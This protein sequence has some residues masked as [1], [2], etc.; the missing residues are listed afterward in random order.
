MRRYNTFSKIV[1]SYF[2]SD[3]IINFYSNLK[4]RSE[5]KILFERYLKN[6][7]NV[8]DLF[9]A[10][11][12][13][14]IF[15]AKKGFYVIG[16]DNNKKMIKK[17]RELAKNEKINNIKFFCIDVSKIKFK[18]ESF[19]Y[20]IAMENSLEHVPNSYT[21][22]KIFKK[23]FGVLKKGGTF[24]TSFHSIFYPPMPSIFINYIENF[25][26]ILL[27]KNQQKFNDVIFKDRESNLFIYAHYFTPFEIKII[28]KSCGFS[29]YKIFSINE[30]NQKNNKIKNIKIY[31]FLRPFL[32]C[33]YIIKK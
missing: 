13:N 15:L 11:G 12:R 8:L 10:T 16:V 24:I 29:S 28:I 20:I 33:Y 22:Q 18:Q 19:D 6:K 3:K 21:R 30:L 31:S 7:G 25:C 4:L 26:K 27:S 32:Y 23:I 9:C 2:S 1:K 5:E 17:A 14:A